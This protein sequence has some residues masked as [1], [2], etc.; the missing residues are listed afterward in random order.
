LDHFIEL[1]NNSSGGNNIIKEL[2]SN[3]NI[4]KYIDNIY[5]WD[6]INADFFE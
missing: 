2:E 3:I 1:N 4:L 6:I 5:K